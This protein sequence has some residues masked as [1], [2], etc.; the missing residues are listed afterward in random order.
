ML[1]NNMNSILVNSSVELSQ[2]LLEMIQEANLYLHKSN[3]KTRQI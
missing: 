2:L 3:K 1:A